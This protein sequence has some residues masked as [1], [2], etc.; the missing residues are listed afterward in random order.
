MAARLQQAARGLND[1]PRLWRN[2][3]D[4]VLRDY[5]LILARADR[6]CSDKPGTI[7]SVPKTALQKHVLFADETRSV[8]S[9]PSVLE[10]MSPA[11]SD[12]F[13]SSQLSGREAK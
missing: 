1:A 13:A 12:V 11:T 4:K 5:G 9:A 7:A 2:R 10:A 6:S 3:L 8:Q